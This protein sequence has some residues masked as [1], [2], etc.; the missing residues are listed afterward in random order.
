MYKFYTGE[1]NDAMKYQLHQGHVRCINWM[2]D[3]SGF[4]SGGWD[5]NVFVWKLFTD[6]NDPKDVNPKHAFMIKNFQ[7]ASVVNKPDSKSVVYAAGIDKTVK[8]IDSGK[9]VMTYEAGANIS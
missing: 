1:T 2:E 4:I 5:G 6:P 8:V 3:D 9:L 7:F